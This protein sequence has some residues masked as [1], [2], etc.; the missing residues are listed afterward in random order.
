MYDLVLELTYYRRFY[1]L[2]IEQGLNTSIYMV[3]SSRVKLR[4]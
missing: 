3:R 2:M 4:E 1:W